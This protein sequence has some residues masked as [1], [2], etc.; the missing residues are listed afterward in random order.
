MTLWT[1]HVC[2][3]L[4]MGVFAWTGWG[5]RASLVRAEQGCATEF[6]HHFAHSW[7]IHPKNKKG[8]VFPDNAKPA[9]SGLSAFWRF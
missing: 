1:L 2:L 3:F 5:G 4:V 7:R 8:N 9:D 6:L